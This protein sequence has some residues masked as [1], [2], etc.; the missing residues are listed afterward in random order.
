MAS[1]LCRLFLEKREA[2][3]RDGKEEA[4]AK[5]EEQCEKKK[6]SINPCR[7]TCYGVFIAAF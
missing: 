1:F 3:P 4:A 7:E 2:Q 6:S 5:K